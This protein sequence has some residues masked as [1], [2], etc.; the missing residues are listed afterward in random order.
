MTGSRRK[1]ALCPWLFRLVVSVVDLRHKAAILRWSFAAI[2]RG[3]R[4]AVAQRLVERLPA[5][6]SSSCFRPLH[7]DGAQWTQS[8]SPA[9]SDLVPLPGK[10]EMDNRCRQQLIQA[11]SPQ[12][13]VRDFQQ[14]GSCLDRRDVCVCVFTA[15]IDGLLLPVHD[16]RGCNDAFAHAQ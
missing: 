10:Q 9:A 1:E 3:P 7:K 6:C 16:S 11:D 4:P 12:G 15:S 14:H 2:S 5:C 8:L 13:C